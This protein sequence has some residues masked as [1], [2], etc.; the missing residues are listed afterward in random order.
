MKKMNIKEWDILFEE[1]YKKIE[2]IGGSIHHQIGTDYINYFPIVDLW[3]NLTTKGYSYLDPY[4][5]PV[6]KSDKFYIEVDLRRGEKES[7]IDKSIFDLEN[8][9]F[10]L[11]INELIG[12]HSY[13]ISFSI[14]HCKFG[15][16]ESKTIDFEMNYIL[17]TAMGLLTQKS[18][19]TK[20]EFKMGNFKTKLIVADLR[21]VVPKGESIN[22]ILDQID[23]SLIHI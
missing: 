1:L 4:L 5:G 14:P 20:E 22:K 11:P 6:D 18:G 15:K 16:I 21:V 17:D 23:L 3:L 9:T 19:R 2:P 10:N 7:F 8:Q 13:D 12:V